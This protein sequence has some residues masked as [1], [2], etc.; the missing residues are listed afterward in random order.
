[1]LSWNVITKVWWNNISLW[2]SL[3]VIFLNVCLLYN[4][5]GSGVSWRRRIVWESSGSRHWTRIIRWAGSWTGI[6]SSSMRGWRGKFHSSGLSVACI[7]R[8]DLYKLIVRVSSLQ[9]RGW[10]FALQVHNSAAKLWF[11]IM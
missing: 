2:L 7:K 8:M 6:W 9:T 3:F 4:S 5:T 11:P 10:K 1:M